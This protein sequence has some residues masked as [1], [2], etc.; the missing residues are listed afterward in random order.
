M[1]TS[2]LTLIGGLAGSLHG[3][4]YSERQGREGNV[5]YSIVFFVTYAHIVGGM[6]VGS[7]VVNAIGRWR[8]RA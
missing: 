6:I 5:T 8:L 1:N 4:C 3:Y 2:M 7:V